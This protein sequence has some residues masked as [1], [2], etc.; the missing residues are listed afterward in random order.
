L[1]TDDEL[2]QRFGAVLTAPSSGYRL[3]V[4]LH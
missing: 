1:E 4:V 3:R 2:V